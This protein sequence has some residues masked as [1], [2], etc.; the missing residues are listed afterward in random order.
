MNGTAQICSGFLSWAVY[1]M[2]DRVLAPWRLFMIICGIVTLIMG[3]VFWFF[4]PDSP[5]TARFLSEREKVVAVER[6]SHQSSGI[7]NKT[8]KK[9]QF[10]EAMT[11]WKV[12][13]VSFPA[14][15]VL[16]TV[17]LPGFHR[18]AS[19][20]SD[21]PVGYYHQYVEI[22]G[23]PLT[24]QSPLASQLETQRFWAWRLVPL[25]SLPSYQAACSSKHSPTR[26]VSSV[27][28]TTFQRK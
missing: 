19:Q 21:K 12:W 25:R 20:L 2:D 9:E 22:N 16:M 15:P 7:E 26:A 24:R 13:A 10:I 14:R 27:L 17:L 5:M 8:W 6:L 28:C 11:D 3:I 23:C 18:S 4:V 1:H